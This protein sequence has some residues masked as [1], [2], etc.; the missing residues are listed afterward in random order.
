MDLRDHGGSVRTEVDFGAADVVSDVIEL[1]HAEG[2][3]HVIPLGL[4]HA[5]W[6]AIELRRR[7]GPARV[8]G[9]VLLDWMVLGP[10]PGFVE[11]LAGLQRER[12]WES[13]RAGLF[14]MWTT[15]VDV[16][17]V[18]RYVEGMAEYGFG[19]W[20]RAGREIA[21]AFAA[22]G[23]PLAALERLA[24]PCPTLHLYAQPRD[25]AVPD[26]QREYAERHRWF[27]AH[28]LT[29]RSHFPTFE[30]PGEIAAAIEEFVCT[31]G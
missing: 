14:G 13:V 25:D 18:H 28:R 11:A 30:V 9:I 5:G 24:Q 27:R 10:P 7:L 17:A 22:E 12:S 6:V 4:S 26:A 20:R 3:T 19:H 16:A 29:A 1:V 23:A 2:L 21:A 15:G 31:L 8:P